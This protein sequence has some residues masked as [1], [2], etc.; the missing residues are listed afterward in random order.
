[1]T[2]AMA[3]GIKPHRFWHLTYREIYNALAGDAVRRRRDRQAIMFGAWHGAALERSKR[4]PNLQQLLAKMEP[5][6]E[7]S[8]REMRSSLMGIAKAMNAEVVYRKRG[9]A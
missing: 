7:M 9:E 2:E 6:R 4:I 3:A 8:S 5:R 1:M